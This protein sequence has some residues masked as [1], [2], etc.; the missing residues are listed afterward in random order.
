MWRVSS[1]DLENLRGQVS[2]GQA[3]G[4]SLGGVRERPSVGLLRFAFNKE[5]P[6]FAGRPL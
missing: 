4:R 5:L 1:S 6:A 3:Y 2:T